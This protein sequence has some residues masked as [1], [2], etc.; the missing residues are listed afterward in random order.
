MQWY[1]SN[2]GQ[3]MG[4]V[5]QSEFDQLVHDGVILADTLVWK[6]GMADWRPYSGVAPAG[7]SPLAPDTEIC[8]VSGKRYPR[9][10]MVQY[11]GKWISAEHRDEYFER[12]REGIP[13]PGQFVYAGF[14]LRFCAKFIDGLVIWIIS[15]GINMLVAFLILGSPNFFGQALMRHPAHDRLVFQAVSFPL[16]IG[17]AI[18][19]ACFFILRWDATPGKMA[20][21]LKLVRSNGERL[22][23]G[24]IAGRYFSEWLSALILCIGYLMVIGDSEKRALHDRICDTRVIRAK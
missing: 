12:I 19:Y 22:S 15:T 21:G 5:S 2:K 16:G 7:G 13:Q 3:R 20:L 9:R 8:A 24:R 1:Y 4:P 10:E 23:A 6:E 14:W 17:L 18:G 11:E